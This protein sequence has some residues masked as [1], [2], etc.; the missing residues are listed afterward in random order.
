MLIYSIVEKDSKQCIYVG[1]TR[2]TLNQRMCS[3]RSKFKYNPNHS[4][5][6]KFLKQNG[7][8]ETVEFIQ[9]ETV[10]SKNTY[11]LLQRERYYFDLLKPSCNKHRPYLTTEEYVESRKQKDR[12]Y[13][14][15]HHEEKKQKHRDWSKFQRKK[16]QSIQ[17]L[18]DS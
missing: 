17:E 1:S 5:L 16:S 9:L 12:N 2:K 13:Y 14:Y 18:N 10:D 3:H 7:G 4:P 8:F 15:S 6:Y 11:D